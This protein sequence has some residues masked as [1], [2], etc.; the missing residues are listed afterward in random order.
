V[1]LKEIKEGEK[2]EKMKIL[3]YLGARKDGTVYAWSLIILEDNKKYY[4]AKNGNYYL[5]L[6]EN[7]NG[8]EIYVDDDDI[9]SYISKDSPD[10]ERVLEQWR[11]ERD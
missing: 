4:L 9:I 8:E 3:E 5:N 7:N 11:E 2:G 1:K 10:V 6:N